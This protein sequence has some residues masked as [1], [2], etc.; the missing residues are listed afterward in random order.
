[1][2]K[3]CWYYENH[4]HAVAVYSDKATPITMYCKLIIMIFCCFCSNNYFCSTLVT[5]WF[6]NNT[7]QLL[8]SY[9]IV[10]ILILEIYYYNII[11]TV[12]EGIFTTLNYYYYYLGR[13]QVSQNCFDSVSLHP[14]RSVFIIFFSHCCI[15][16]RFIDLKYLW[17][18]ISDRF[19]ERSTAHYV[20]PTRIIYCIIIV[21]IS[22]EG[23]NEINSHFR[24]FTN[25]KYIQF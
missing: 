6:N 9:Y 21:L 17:L 16:H 14:R 8:Y 13:Y 10:Y 19:S 12:A 5:G 3:Y 1:M 18:W 15:E 2:K 23:S 7:I 25:T 4:V 22:I 20:Q 11:Y 24:F